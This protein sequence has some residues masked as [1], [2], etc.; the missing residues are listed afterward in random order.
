[1]QDENTLAGSET[2]ETPQPDPESGAAPETPATE[3]QPSGTDASAASELEK[4]EDQ[5]A[6][7]KDPTEDKPEA[8]AQPKRKGTRPS[9]R[10]AKLT[11]DLR[12]AE[13]QRDSALRRADRLEERLGKED[14]KPNASTFDTDE[15]YQAELTAWNVRQAS[16]A[17]RKADVDEAREQAKEA[18]ADALRI[19]RSTFMERAA[20]F[21]ETSPDFFERLNDP[22]LSISAEMASEIY[23]S[24]V[25]PQLV[26]FLSENKGEALRIAALRDRSAVTREMARLEGRISQPA[27]KRV[28]QAPAPVKSVATGAGSQQTFNAATASV[29]DI[30]KRLRAKNIIV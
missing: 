15:D 24:D 27:P 21:A 4:T 10:I 28:S 19:A 17:D 8:K 29:D 23:G 20:E 22:G 12:N 18:D 25:G 9:E 1:M 5:K 3:D 16:K 26:H 30:A 2:V 13:A 7:G 6:N 14:P 11:A